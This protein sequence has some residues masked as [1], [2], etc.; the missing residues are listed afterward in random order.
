MV[1]RE[2]L[3]VESDLPLKSPTLAAFTASTGCWLLS[4]AC[5]HTRR[6]EAALTAT[7]GCQT[8]HT[9]RHICSAFPA[10]N[11][12]RALQPPS[13]HTYTPLPAYLTCLPI[14]VATV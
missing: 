10:A 9:A 7:G 12:Y 1:S 11:S 14:K 8:L 4:T 3:I 13:S 5:R 2:V 6:G